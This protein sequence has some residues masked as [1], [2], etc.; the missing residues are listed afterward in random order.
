M[1]RLARTTRFL[2][3][4]A[5]LAATA[6]LAATVRCTTC[7]KVIR[8]KYV[9]SAGRPYCSQACYQQTLPKCAVCG[10]AITGRYVK[11][12]GRDFCSQTCLEKTL[13]KCEICGKALREFT[14]IHGH[15]Y[16][17]QHA[18]GPR[19][20]ACGLPLVKGKALPDKRLLCSRC[21]TRVV[22]DSRDAQAIYERAAREVKGITGVDLVPLPPLELVGREAMP[23]SQKGLAV[24]NVQERGF[25]RNEEITDTYKDGRGKVIRV[26][27]EVKEN[28]YILYGLTPEEL[29]CTSAHELTHAMQS[30]ALPNIHEKAPLWLKEGIC[31]YVAADVARRHHYA[32]ELEA[33]E[34]SP[35]PAYGRGYRYLQKRF[36]N[37]QWQKLHAWLRSIDPGK[38]PADLPADL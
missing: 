3:L 1:T 34:K 24:E 36:G 13:P 28:V 26:E 38:L 19:C 14:K 12:M 6:A 17:R 18:E 23:A 10:K 2:A 7:G 4:L 27:R 37:G 20:D 35:H 29:L 16:C 11:H 15:V 32:D 31:Q 22:L 30:R 8:G 5:L 25:F 9:V 21:E 33:I